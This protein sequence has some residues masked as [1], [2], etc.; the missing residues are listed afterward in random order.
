M[1]AKELRFLALRPG[2]QTQFVRLLKMRMDRHHSHTEAVGSAVGSGDGA[3]IKIVPLAFQ[4]RTSIEDRNGR[5]LDST[6]IGFAVVSLDADVI[7]ADRAKMN[8]RGNLQR[9][10]HLDVLAIG[11]SD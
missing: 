9:F 8:F 3:L 11:I 1:T 2:D 7:R 6:V 10:A 5:I 4:W